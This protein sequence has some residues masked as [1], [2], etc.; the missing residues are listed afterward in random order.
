M[1]GVGEWGSGE[2]DKSC[3]VAVLPTSQG[4]MNSALYHHEAGP[5]QA[6]RTLEWGFR[7][8]STT[9]QCLLPPWASVSPLIYW[10]C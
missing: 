6:R 10:E 5:C 7:P 4:E 8:S 1:C 2:K 3:K 9:D